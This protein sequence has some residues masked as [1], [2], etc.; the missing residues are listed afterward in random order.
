MIST[1]EEYISAHT[2][3]HEQYKVKYD[4]D[5]FLNAYVLVLLYLFFCLIGPM[6]Y[7]SHGIW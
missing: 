7:S 2:G 1:I 3:E 5:C 6:G 4:V